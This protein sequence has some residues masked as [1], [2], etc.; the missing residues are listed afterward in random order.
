MYNLLYNQYTMALKGK[1]KSKKTWLEAARGD[2]RIYVMGALM[3]NISTTPT[4][5]PFVGHAYRSHDYNIE[6]KCKK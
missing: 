2:S 6:E 3:A 1:S 4:S 5:A